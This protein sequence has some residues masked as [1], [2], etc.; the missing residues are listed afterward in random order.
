MQRD[1]AEMQLRSGPKCYLR[2]LKIKCNKKWLSL[3]ITKSDFG[4]NLESGIDVNLKK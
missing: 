3:S 2:L 4:Q 1:F